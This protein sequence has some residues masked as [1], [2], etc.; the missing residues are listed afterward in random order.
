M[1]TFA[2]PA[3]IYIE[4]D[5]KDEAL[6]QLGKMRTETEHGISFQD[7]CYESYTDKDDKIKWKKIPA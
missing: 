2:Y 6:K 7:T 4:A 3:I 1:T 5:S